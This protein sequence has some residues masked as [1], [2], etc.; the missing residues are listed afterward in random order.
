MINL[1]ET[2]NDVSQK[3]QHSLYLADYR[4]PTIVMD[5]NGFL[6]DDVISP[7]KF[8]ANYKQFKDDT[9]TFFNEVN[10]PPLWEIAG[11]QNIAEIIDNGKVRGRIFYREHFKNRIVNFVEWFDEKDRLRSVDHY[12]KEGVKFAQTVYDLEKTPILKT[13]VNREGKEVI[14]ENFVTKDIVL[15]WKGQS[16]FFASKHDFIIFFL[17]QLD[18]DISK[19]I[20]NSLATPFFVLYYSDFVKQA[21]LFWQE[22]S[23]SHVPGNMELLLDKEHCQTSVIIPDKQEYERIISHIE[24]NYIDSIQSAGYLYNYQRNN[25]YTKRILNLTNSDD[26]PYIEELIKLHPEFEFHIGAITEMSSKLLNLEQYSNVVLYPTVTPKTVDRLFKKCDIYLDVNHG[27][28]ILNALERA[29]LNNQLILGYKETIH[30]PSFVADDNIIS[31]QHYHDLSNILNIIVKNKEQ[32]K[33]RLKQQKLHNNQID[34]RQFKKTLKQ[35]L[36]S[37]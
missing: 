17:N 20:I 30:R 19:I 33:E 6:P 37:I 16:H 9:P 14:Y 10:I 7:Y 29:M 31:M 27:G 21:V 32:F 5:D 8:F 23:E 25:K 13:Y 4:H 11:N 22:N 2:F 34:K 1:F 36:G 18:I 24:A 26:I 15:D 12:T 35:I 3:L 28:E